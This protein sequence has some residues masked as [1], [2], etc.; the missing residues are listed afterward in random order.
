MPLKDMGQRVKQIYSESSGCAP[1]V[2]TQATLPPSYT[3]LRT[4]SVH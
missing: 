4:S 2:S 3:V 1:T